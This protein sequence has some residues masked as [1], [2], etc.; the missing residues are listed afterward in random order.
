VI[1][2]EKH[3]A[4]EKEN[5]QLKAQ[6]HSLQNQLDAVVKLLSG[7]KNEKRNFVGIDQI[8]LFSTPESD[9]QQENEKDASASEPAKRKDEPT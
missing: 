6:L 4:L 9:E 5:T 3:Q 7:K 8:G 1:S 2:L